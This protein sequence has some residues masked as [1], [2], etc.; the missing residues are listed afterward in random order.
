MTQSF[1]AIETKLESL[2]KKLPSLPTDVKDLIV[3]YGPYVV[4]VG[5]AITL[6]ST[7]SAFLSGGFGALSG[8]LVL[9][10]YLYLVFNVV[11]GLILIRAYK[12]LMARQL[13]G[14][15]V[16]FYAMLLYLAITAIS[17]ILFPAFYLF[18]F[19]GPLISIYL[20]FEVKS[21]YH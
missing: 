6:L 17:F 19:A 1:D 5:G 3:K 18:A 2:F 4:L 20:L 15:R 21:Y 10:N 9:N 11:V 14:W 13:T 7:A 8:R 16:L 12:P